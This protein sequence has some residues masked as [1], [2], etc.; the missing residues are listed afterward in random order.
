M[1]QKNSYVVCGVRSHNLAVFHDTI[2]RFPGR[3]IFVSKRDDLCL[4]NLE[5]LDPRY[6]FFLHWSWFVPEEIHTKYECINFHM[7]DLPYGR[8]GSPLQNLILRG[9]ADTVL[10]AHYMTDQIDSGAI[11]LKQ[12][13]S[14][15]G[16]ANDI[17]S[18]ASHLAASMIRTI[19]DNEPTPLPQVGMPTNFTRRVP[20]Q[21]EVPHEIE[22]LS[23]LYDYIRMLDGEGYPPAYFCGTHFRYEFR[24]AQ[25]E[26][27]ELH[28]SVTITKI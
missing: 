16:S 8:G 20:K 15:D 25:L 24:S 5:Q 19:V 13:L 11:Y 17:L 6:V 14:L 28:A 21:S 9:H 3:W 23:D 7:T 12:T 10:T 1:N 26:G 4:E 2:S 18:R 27:N 22:K